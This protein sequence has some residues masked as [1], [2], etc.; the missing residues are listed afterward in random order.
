ML[1]VDHVH[2]SQLEY[3][4][5][6][7]RPRAGGRAHAVRVTQ[8]PTQDG[9]PTALSSY[10]TALDRNSGASQLTRCGWRRP[11]SM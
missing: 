8:R 10:G 2:A 5:Y 4:Y 7:G 1:R 3:D 9:S 11:K 6:G